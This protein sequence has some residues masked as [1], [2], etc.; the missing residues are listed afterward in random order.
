VKM[1]NPLPSKRA[2][3]LEPGN[4]TKP[5]ESATMGGDGGRETFAGGEYHHGQLLGQ[6]GAAC[7]PLPLLVKPSA[8]RGWRLTPA[9]PGHS[10]SGGP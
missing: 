5:L 8:L 2:S 10:Q 9:L 4:Q 3:P 1:R 6:G 7:H